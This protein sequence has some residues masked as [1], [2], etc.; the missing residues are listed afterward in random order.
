MYEGSRSS[1]IIASLLDDNR[2]IREE[3]AYCNLYVFRNQADARSFQD[4][5][6][7]SSL[8]YD[9]DYSTLGTQS[10]NGC[11]PTNGSKTIYFGFENERMRY[12]NYL[13]LEAVTT[14]NSTE[15]Y[16]HV[17]SIR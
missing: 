2:P 16:K 5:K 11:I 14:G 17:Y 8:K 15:Y 10:C 4:G 6:S 3:D 12:T 13:W 9:V 1:G 7:V